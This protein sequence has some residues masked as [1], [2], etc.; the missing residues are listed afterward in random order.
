MDKLTKAER[1]ENMR[2]ILGKNTAPEMVVRRIVSNLGYRYRIHAKHLAGKPDLVITRNRKIIFVHGCF[3]HLHPASGCKDARIPKSRVGY[4]T[5]K[6]RRN[7]AR[8]KRHLADLRKEGWEAMI[9]WEC[10]TERS[11][12]SLTARIQRFL[13]S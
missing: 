10:Q 13:N 3:W 12:P 6:L 8:D 11:L 9:V 7:S 5:Q 4:W 1:S 2:R